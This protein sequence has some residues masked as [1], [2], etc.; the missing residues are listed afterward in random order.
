MNDF[1]K[2][3]LKSGLVCSIRPLPYDTWEELEVRRTDLLEKGLGEDAKTG[4]FTIDQR[5][6]I[7]QERRIRLRTCVDS[8]DKVSAQVSMADVTELLNLIDKLSFP[9]LEK[10]N[11]SGAGDGRQTASA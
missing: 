10:E 1:S 7:L 8:W 4:K 6:F 2:M 11:L 3:T 9:D 5:K